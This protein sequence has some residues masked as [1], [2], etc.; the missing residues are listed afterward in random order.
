VSCSSQDAHGEHSYQHLS[1]AYNATTSGRAAC[2]L[3]GVQSPFP[4][5]ELCCRGRMVTS[6]RHLP[7]VPATAMIL[8]NEAISVNPP[9]YINPQMTSFHDQHHY[10]LHGCLEHRSAYERHDVGGQKSNASSH[11]FSTD[12]S[13]FD[14]STRE[15]VQQFS[16]PTRRLYDGQKSERLS[17]DALGHYCT[18]QQLNTADTL[19]SK[20]QRL[21][22]GY[23]PHCEVTNGQLLDN[24][25]EHRRLT[26]TGQHDTSCQVLRSTTSPFTEDRSVFS[27]GRSVTKDEEFDNQCSLSK[28]KLKT[29]EAAPANKPFND[30][31][32]EI[33]VSHGQYGSTTSPAAV[34]NYYTRNSSVDE[35]AKRDFSVYLFILQMY[36]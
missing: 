30:W 13:V 19:V 35:I 7:A 1:G 11:C 20:G 14:D 16:P 10:P 5:C 36:M 27:A 9:C 3:D 29:D 32:N 17:A 6:L 21:V 18:G 31:K 24:A 8:D 25:V 34:A 26:A 23:I 22:A 2:R 4:V 15:C 33:T 28:S 12:N